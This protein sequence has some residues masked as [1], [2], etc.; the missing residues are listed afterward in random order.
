MIQQG[1]SASESAASGPAMDV[2]R[3]MDWVD[4]RL[5]A[6]RARE[7]EEEEDEEK[8]R[9]RQAPRSKP[10]PVPAAAPRKRTSPPTPAP[11][12]RS[13]SPSIPASSAPSSSRSMQPPA[14]VPSTPRT[15][16]P[17][18]TTITP[19]VTPLDS[20]SSPLL[21]S[22]QP[23]FSLPV[24]SSDV[25]INI[26]QKRRHALLSLSDTPS[27]DGMN[28]AI[29][30]PATP[31]GTVPGGLVR[32]RVRGLTRGSGTLT[33]SAAANAS[34]PETPDTSMMDVEDEGRE[35]KRVARR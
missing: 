27:P 5:A 14:S 19:S 32:R 1:V 11:A 2:G 35:R 23:I 20:P 30:A 12:H 10:A 8:E 33:P 9:E 13:S 24:V 15:L 34:R 28:M 25:P 3:I 7:E 6:I 31:G 17:R 29:S 26:G 4:A 21:P 18:M 22:V 16:K